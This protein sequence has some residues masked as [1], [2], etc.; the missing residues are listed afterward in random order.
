MPI[1]WLVGPPD[2]GFLVFECLEGWRVQYFSTTADV[3]VKRPGQLLY[4]L[5]CETEN[6]YFWSSLPLI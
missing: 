3:V 4:F 6:L 2:T 5:V 1:N